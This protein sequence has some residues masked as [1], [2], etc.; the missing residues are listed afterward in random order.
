L[1]DEHPF[2][3]ARTGRRSKLFLMGNLN[4]GI[5]VLI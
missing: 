4:I 2:N 5:R 3:K 1:S